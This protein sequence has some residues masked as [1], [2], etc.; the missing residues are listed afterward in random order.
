VYWRHQGG[1]G[2]CIIEIKINDGDR[3]LH[4]VPSFYCSAKEDMNA[5]QQIK[6]Y[7]LLGKKAIKRLLSIM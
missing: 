2:I 6:T 5:I 1:L 3:Y 7:C 4:I